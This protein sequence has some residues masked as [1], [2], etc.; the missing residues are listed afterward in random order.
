M[1]IDISNDKY[2][3]YLKKEQISNIDFSSKIEVEELFKNLFLKIKKLNNIE[4]KGFFYIKV[5]LNEFF[6]AV[7]EFVR[8][9]VEYYDY[10]SN[11]IDMQIEI[12]DDSIILKE[13]ENIDDVKDNMFYLYDEKYYTKYTNDFDSEFYRIVYGEET[14][15][16]VDNSLICYLKKV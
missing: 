10:L 7:L 9:E 8:D 14:N 2:I 13:Y 6:G 11:K 4:L 5:Y 15:Y 16:I 3:V 12:M 1:N